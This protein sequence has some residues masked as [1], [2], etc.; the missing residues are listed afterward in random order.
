MCYGPQ[1]IVHLLWYTMFHTDQGYLP[2]KVCL[3]LH[4]EQYSSPEAVV[5]P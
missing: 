2:S 4:R 5:V 1:G 3:P